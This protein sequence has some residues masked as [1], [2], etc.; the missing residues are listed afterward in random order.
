MN[1]RLVSVIVPVYNV[2]GQVVTCITSLVKQTYGKIEIIL[3]DDGS[4]DG[5]SEILEE[6]RAK[7]PRIK[8]IHTVNGGVTAARRR[9]WE[10]AKG[11]YCLFVDGD[12]SL[13]P[14]AVAYFVGIS[15]R[16]NYDIISGTYDIVYANGET[17]SKS[18]TLWG[19]FSTA[20]YIRDMLRL[21]GGLPSICI[22][23]FKTSL[24]DDAVF[25][26]GRNIVRGEDA[27]LLSGLLN[28]TDR[29][30]CTDKV[31]YHYYQR[32]DSVTHRV[33]L[34]PE[35]ML[36]IVQLQQRIVRE[37]YKM[38]FY[39]VHLKMSLAAYYAIVERDG[40]CR[41][42]ALR[43]KEMLAVYPAG[44]EKDLSPA[45]KIKY[46]FLPFKLAVVF[47]GFLMKLWHLWRK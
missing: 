41:E 9:G 46:V 27:L 18:V 24:F 30:Y 42:N 23:M 15:L 12:D 13:V 37:E 22:G 4:T 36:E 25:N 6:W 44:C 43:I 5:C 34:P 29:I 19:E 20:D 14:D 3:V 11:E 38:F 10:E 21:T 32:E 35:Y 47:I 1:D 2:I 45:E 31:F 33:I 17:V 40:W 7:D 26:I 16:G 28:R 8:V 39:P